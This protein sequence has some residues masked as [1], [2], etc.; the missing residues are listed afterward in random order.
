MPVRKP[1][2]EHVSLRTEERSDNSEPSY[3]L[4]WYPLPKHRMR[5]TFS[6]KGEAEFEAN[7]IDNLMS[8]GYASM[9][10]LPAPEMALFV[11]QCEQMKVQPHTVMQFYM[12][13]HS[14]N[15]SSEKILV[16]IAGAEFVETRKDHERFSQR[17]YESVKSH[18]KS[19]TLSMGETDIHQVTLGM[20]D[21]YIK[22][23]IGGAPKTRWNHITTL[24][25]FGRWMRLKK[26]WFPLN[27][28]CAFE[29]LERPN[30][31]K[32]K[33]VVYTPE[34]MTRLLVF[35]PTQLLEWMVTGAFGGIRAAERLRLKGQHWQP[36][37][38]QF[39]LD[40]DITKTRTERIAGGSAG[41]PN[42]LDWLGE[43]NV[44]DHEAI[45]A[46]RSPYHWTS[47]IAKAS[48]VPWKHNALRYS[49]A[50]YHL[51]KYKN[52]PLTAMLDGHS[53][54]E[55]NTS[56]RGIKGVNDTTAD[57]YASITRA[58]VIEYARKHQLTNPEWA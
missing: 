8:H 14:T 58:S 27:S 25:S 35:T 24:I 52:P 53:V 54:E 11:M 12:T 57:A 45:V 51:Q 50:S 22:D 44:G 33:K 26:K 23:E 41:F 28:L 30:V 39:S 31:P 1:G 48:G 5:K 46:C 20:L 10:K 36:D 55:L 15:G 21:Q 32:K 3:V 2:F 47:K 38:G 37:H 17:Q 40:A 34:E 9:T 56:Y 43:I 7:R 19:L 13:H 29:E 4:T 16:K 6:D 42:L 49:F 18:I